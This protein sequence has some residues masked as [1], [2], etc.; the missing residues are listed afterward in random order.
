MI[1]RPMNLNSFLIPIQSL[2][3]SIT[4]ILHI[5]TFDTSE[6]EGKIVKVVVRKKSK[7]L[8]FEKFID[9][10]HKSGCST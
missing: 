4:K 1:P 2:R 7:Q 6:M 5:R 8:A 3:K 9:K 10:I